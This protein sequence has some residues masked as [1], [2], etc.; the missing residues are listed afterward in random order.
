[1]AFQGNLFENCCIFR[2]H[3]GPN[4]NYQTTFNLT[5]AD[6]YAINNEKSL[7]E[8]RHIVELS[9]TSIHHYSPGIKVPINTLRAVQVIRSVALY[10]R[11]RPFS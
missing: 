6:C 1:M 5:N 11:E 9:S 8:H 2:L 4:C 10:D 7:M 3:H